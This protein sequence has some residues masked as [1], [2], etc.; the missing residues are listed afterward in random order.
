M[1]II[2][3]DNFNREYISDRLVGEG[4][5]DLEGQ[6]AVDALNAK[7]SGK[8]SSVY[9]ELVPDDYELFIFKP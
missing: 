9:Y 4:L 7:F 1:K 8:Q 2:C 5:N 6:I 3:V